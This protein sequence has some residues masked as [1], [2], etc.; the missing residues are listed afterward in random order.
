MEK[1]YTIT[2]KRTYIVTAEETTPVKNKPII[3]NADKEEII[4]E[5]TISDVKEK[6]CFKRY[7]KRVMENIVI[8]S[9]LITCILFFCFGP[10]FNDESC[11]LILSFT[12]ILLPL[13]HRLID[14]YNDIKYGSIASVVLSLSI[15]ILLYYVSY[16][17]LS[18][19]N[20][21]LNIL[22]A[23]TLNITTLTNFLSS[24]IFVCHIISAI[25]LYSK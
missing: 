11:M 3:A 22:K 2:V 20:L 5:E 21:T 25:K 24:I 13:A 19:L 10:L 14:H 18:K 4:K 12:S 9:F 16:P 17:F 8:I 6:K 1:T 7:F 23:I 15:A